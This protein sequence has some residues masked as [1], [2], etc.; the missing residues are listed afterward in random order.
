MAFHL[1]DL[2]YS[3]NALAPYISEETLRYHHGKHHATYV[4]KLNGLLESGSLTN[5]DLPA[6]IR[7]NPTGP[8]FNNAAQIW[9]HAFYWNSLTPNSA[10]PAGEI[11]KAIDAQFGSYDQF[12]EE[13]T[14]ACLGLFGSGW[15]WLSVDSDNKLQIEALPN[16]HTPISGNNK[17]LITCD[18][19]EHAYYI[20]T[21]NDRGLYLKNFWELVNW[22]FAEDNLNQ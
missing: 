12:K 2:P 1:S 11:G 3:A 21:R 4:N 13:F 6:I 8:I 10:N 17:P 22:S 15:V 20:D 5:N 18:V 9:N 19:W 16:A 14:K 7:D